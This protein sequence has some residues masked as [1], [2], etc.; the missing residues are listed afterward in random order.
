MIAVDTNLEIYTFQ[1]I[2]IIPE[3]INANMV[4]LAK[5]PGHFFIISHIRILQGGF[6][7]Y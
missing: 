6:Y 5:Q 7:C 3:T 4:M 2:N 1:T